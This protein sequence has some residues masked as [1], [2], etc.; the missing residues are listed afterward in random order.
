MISAYST[1]VPTIALGYSIKSRGIAK[2]LNVEDA[3]VVDS[4]KNE[5]IIERFR[6][7]VE[8]ETQIKETLRA[9]L[10]SYIG[11]FKELK[12]YIGE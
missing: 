3:F 10:P 4:N 2:D 9:S 5:D 11:K 7:L 8:D 6:L 12:K 1:H